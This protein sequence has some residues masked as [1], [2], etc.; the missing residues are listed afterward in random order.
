MEYFAQNVIRIELYGL[1]K[2][3]AT[4]V[5]SCCDKFIQTPFRQGANATLSTHDMDG[6]II[7][8]FACDYCILYVNGHEE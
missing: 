2:F 5:L 1:L 7:K 4:F 8:Q 3:I 6:Y